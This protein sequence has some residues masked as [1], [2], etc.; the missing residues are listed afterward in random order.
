MRRVDEQRLNGAVQLALVA[1]HYER[2]GDHAVTIAEQVHFVATGEHASTAAVPAMTPPD[3]TLGPATCGE[4]G[5]G[6][7]G[8]PGPALSVRALRRPRTPNREEPDPGTALGGGIL[9]PFSVDDHSTG[10]GFPR[11]CPCV[12]GR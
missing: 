9:E 1:R 3:R 11:R 2:I 10:A 12:A 8:F 4:R 7:G 5:A 6:K